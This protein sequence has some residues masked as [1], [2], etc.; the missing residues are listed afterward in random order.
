MKKSDLKKILKP[1]VKECIQEA[2][3]EEGLLSNVI[4]EVVAGLGAG[5]QPIVEQKQNNDEINKMQLE[6]KK[7]RSQKI[8][9]TRQKMLDAVGNSSYNGVDLFEGT[10]PLGRSGSPGEAQQAQGA[11]SDVAPGDA[12]ID[13]SNLMGNISTWKQLAGNDK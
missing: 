11:L 8:N 12:G 1:L 6:E 3:L 4:A 7:K 10:T 13:I 9:E 5:Q 2:L